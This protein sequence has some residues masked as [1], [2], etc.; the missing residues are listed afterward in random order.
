M[1]KRDQSERRSITHS[2]VNVKI[3]VTDCHECTTRCASVSSLSSQFA[4]TET[5]SDEEL[6]RVYGRR[7]L[8]TDGSMFSQNIPNFPLC[9]AG[10]V[11]RI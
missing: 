7:L 2:L 6:R 1:N 4:T 9:S 11:D 5:P 10:D 8:L 3:H